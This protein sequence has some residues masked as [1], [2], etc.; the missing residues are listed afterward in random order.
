MRII[1]LLVQK[2]T[3]RP[4][5]RPTTSVAKLQAQSELPDSGGKVVGMPANTPCASVPKLFGMQASLMTDSANH[6]PVEL[7]A[8]IF[9]ILQ[10]DFLPGILQSEHHDLLFACQSS[11]WQLQSVCKAFQATFKRHPELCSHIHM[12]DHMLDE[13][14]LSLLAWL[15]AH[16]SVLKSFRALSEH[17]QNPQCLLALSDSHCSLEFASL[18]VA[19]Q[20]VLGAFTALTTCFLRSQFTLSELPPCPS[21]AFANPGYPDAWGFGEG[22]FTN[23]NAAGHLTSLEVHYARVMSRSDCRFCTCLVKLQI[24]HNGV[25]DIHARGLCACTA[26]QFLQVGCECCIDA[27]DSSNVLDT[28]AY[29]FVLPSSISCLTALTT[30]DLKYDNF[31]SRQQADMS[32]ISMLASLEALTLVAYGG[33]RVNQEV[34]ALTRLTSR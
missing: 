1:V 20:A 11:F 14:E 31:S 8:R 10:P 7:W 4:A 2:H 21:D 19:S 5:S 12:S 6:L 16:G 32:R 17:A 29:N 15:R 13:A 24:T 34:E 9:G 18:N 22:W 33:F 23:F 28:C 25:V 30:L 3:S 26:L 27:Q